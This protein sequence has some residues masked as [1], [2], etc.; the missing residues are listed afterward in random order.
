MIRV[1]VVDDNDMMRRGLS[2]TIS[3]EPG[4]ETVGAAENAEEAFAM[5]NGAFCVRK[6]DR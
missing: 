2:E 6:C 4:M 3:V 1:M 5:F